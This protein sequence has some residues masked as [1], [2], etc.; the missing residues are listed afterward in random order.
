M[1]VGMHGNAD[2]KKYLKGKHAMTP[3]CVNASKQSTNDSI[4]SHMWNAIMAYMSDQAYWVPPMPMQ[5]LSDPSN[6][7]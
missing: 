3:P 6:Y 1:I 2:D 7:A 5:E 4:V